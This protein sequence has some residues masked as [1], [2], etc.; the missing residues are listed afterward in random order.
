MQNNCPSSGVDSNQSTDSGIQ[1]F[2]SLSR[3]ALYAPLNGYLNKSSKKQNINNNVKEK[4][5][6]LFLEKISVEHHSSTSGL[7]KFGGTNGGIP[8]RSRH[9][10]SKAAQRA[11]TLI[12][13]GCNI[14]TAKSTS[15]VSNE[16]VEST[17]NF[18]SNRSKGSKR[19]SNKFI[20]GS[21]S[22]RKR[23]RVSK[24]FEEK[25]EDGSNAKTRT[26]SPKEENVQ[27]RS[28]T[29]EVLTGLNSIWNEYFNSLMKMHNLSSCS[30]S[31][32]DSV[33]RFQIA[34]LMSKTEL[35][36]AEVLVKD[37]S[38]NNM[39]QCGILV[40]ETKHT[41]KIASSS[42][43]YHDSIDEYVT[44]EN[45]EDSTLVLSVTTKSSHIH[46][47]PK[48]EK[49]LIMLLRAPGKVFFI[50]VCSTLQN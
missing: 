26:K 23:K 6:Y 5:L 14:P 49:T 35:I 41:W 46:V 50:H 47:V 33:E 28:I 27:D 22:N 10:E 34:N 7:N 32:V 36:G 2:A 16:N 12:G 30:P 38:T 17:S 48:T 4:S 43:K 15:S 45:V 3:N 8:L 24:T 9:M 37:E 42:R 1:E 21:L 44:K 20:H 39:I 29:E 11:L 40:D 13:N 25:L 18:R 19:R 31:N